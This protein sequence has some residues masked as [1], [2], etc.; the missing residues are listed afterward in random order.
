M[1]L[2]VEKRENRCFYKII[3]HLRYQTLSNILWFYE[4]DSVLNATFFGIYKDN[5]HIQQN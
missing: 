2:K 4:N 3:L 5:R 1:P